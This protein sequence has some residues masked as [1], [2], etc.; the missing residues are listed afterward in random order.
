VVPL[1]RIRNPAL[2]FL[3]RSHTL[4]ANGGP[5]RMTTITT[6]R[7]PPLA[8]A[9]TM[10]RLRSIFGGSA[11]NLIEWFDWYVYSSFALYFAGSFF[12]KGDQTA[13]LLD[14]AAVFAVGFLVRPIGAW[15]MGLYADR[16]GRRAAL[17]LGVAMMCAGSLAVA[18][19][20]DY[21]HIGA[22]APVL[23]VLARLVQGLSLGGE[24]GASAAYL[25]EIA[26]RKHRG[27]WASFQYVTLI[28]GQLLALAVLLVMQ[29]TMS[30]AALHA[31]GWRIA[32]AVGAVLALGV[33]W[34]R[35]HIEETAAFRLEVAGKVRVSRMKVF[36]QHPREALLVLGLTAGGSLAFYAYT[37]YLQKFLANTAGFSKDKAS[38]I[39]AA[40]LFVYM[41]LQ[42]AF[43]ALSDRV[44]RRPLLIAFGVLGMI[45]TYPIMRALGGAHDAFTAFALALSALCI[46][47]CYTAIS[48]LVKAELYPAEIRALGVALPYAVANSLFGGTAEYV[49]LWFKQ[50]GHE[51]WFYVYVSGMCGVALIVALVMH[52][53]GRRSRIL[54]D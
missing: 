43:G 12:P 28:G 2:A 41:C 50:Q 20:P 45:G 42:P 5:P 25:S 37:T 19:I 22:A 33:F 36:F 31:W 46:V 4:P 51:P 48:G 16:A 21:A 44:G 47:S 40:A 18:L 8:R 1:G 39:T 6:D 10:S 30:T 9:G 38:Q 53:T 27:F 23:L 7:P 32:F 14:A 15:L 17:T 35:R 24:Y 49:A 34:I 52:D 13:Q 11:G 26:A 54:E 3:L 29:A